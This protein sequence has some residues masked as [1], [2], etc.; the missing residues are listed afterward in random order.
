M[1]ISLFV[2]WGI[3]FLCCFTGFLYLKFTGQR[4]FIL[5][6]PGNI[7]LQR[8]IRILAVLASVSYIVSGTLWIIT[9]ADSF[10]N[11]F[12]RIIVLTGAFFAVPFMS[13]LIPT[14]LAGLFT[15][16]GKLVRWVWNE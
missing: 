15:A 2:S 7:W 13:I 4:T 14:L 9:K 1:E 11:A 16:P 3:L 5:S 6:C 10:D 8:S 12:I